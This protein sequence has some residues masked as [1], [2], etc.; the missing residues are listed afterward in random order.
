MRVIA[1]VGRAPARAVVQVSS[2]AAG[3]FW[4][5]RSSF[6][7]GPV[8]SAPCAPKEYVYNKNIGYLPFVLEVKNNEL[9]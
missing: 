3:E 5:P 2:T 7:E 9:M 8:F 1:N 6:S 4:A